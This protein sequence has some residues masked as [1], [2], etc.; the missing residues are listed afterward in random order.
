MLK[1]SKRPSILEA[2]SGDDIE[3]LATYI[4][5]QTDKVS[6]S[7]NEEGQLQIFM[8][9]DRKPAGSISFSGGLASE[10]NMNLSWL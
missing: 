6:A 5:G 1:V 7:V 9:G 2:K 3:E 8:A 10:L 4:N